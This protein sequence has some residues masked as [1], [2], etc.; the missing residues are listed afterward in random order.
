MSYNNEMDIRNVYSSN[1][2]S[3]EYDYEHEEKM[4]MYRFLSEVER[5]A[6][7]KNY[8][9]KKIAELYGKSASYITQL[10][11]GTKIMNLESVARFQK[12][13]DVIF[14]I[15]AIPIEQKTT[16]IIAPTY[17]AVSIG[18]FAIQSSAEFK[19]DSSIPTQGSKFLIPASKEIVTNYA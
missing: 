2:L 16:A 15:K 17:K 11:R 19:S 14:E 7:E 5:L 1:F 3:N 18:E 4:V 10:F 6:D 12:V 8:S 9:R 13:F